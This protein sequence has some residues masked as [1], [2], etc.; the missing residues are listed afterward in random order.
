MSVRIRSSV[1]TMALAVAAGSTQATYWTLSSCASRDNVDQTGTRVEAEATLQQNERLYWK[2]GADLDRESAS[3]ISGIPGGS[4]LTGG[5]AATAMTGVAG[6]ALQLGVGSTDISQAQA[7]S[8][9]FQAVRGIPALAGFSGRIELESKR[10]DNT[11]LAYGVRDDKVV[12]AVS[13]DRWNTYAEAGAHVDL[14]SGG[15]DVGAALPVDL[16]DNRVTTLYAWA[17]HRWT[18]FLM[19]GLAAHRTTATA[20]LHQP[21]GVE[22]DSAAS[23]TKYRWAD[24]P[25]TSP[26][27][28]SSV[29]ALAQLDLPH[30]TLNAS[31]PVY[32]VSKL[33]VDDLWPQYYWY[34][35]TAPLDAGATLSWPVS[36]WLAALELKVTSLPYKSWAWFDGSNA[37]T[38]YALTLTL[39]H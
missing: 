13:L 16:P 2:L 37:W 34:R 26:L 9:R 32:S 35:G 12:T 21:V 25:Y 15:H 11:W 23:V 39:R 24:V 28:E 17:T 31:V 7:W 5:A 1:V 22:W 6:F 18:S 3:S 8:I 36:G 27:D 29:N 19:A 38:R 4:R 14:R 20:D 33:R 10:M 30:L